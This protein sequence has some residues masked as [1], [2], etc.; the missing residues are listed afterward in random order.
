[1]SQMSVLLDQYKRLVTTSDNINNSIVALKKRNLLKGQDKSK[2]PNLCITQ[3][4]VEVASEL[5]I[6]FLENVSKL[7]QADAQESEFLPS[8][9]F[10]DYKKRISTK[11]LLEEDLKELISKLKTGEDIG[12]NS[13]SVLDELLSVLDIERRALFQKLRAARA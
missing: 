10:E 13:I 11:Q 3:Q 1:M 7:I 8:L 9:V 2:Y 4:E 6:N 5:L 12:S